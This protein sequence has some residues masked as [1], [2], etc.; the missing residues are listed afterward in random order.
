MTDRRVA[1]LGDRA[2]S[3]E[4]PGDFTLQR[5]REARAV[6]A[7]VR[8]STLPGIRDVVVTGVGVTVHVDPLGAPLDDLEALLRETSA[9]TLLEEDEA[10]PVVIPVRYGGEDGPDLDEVAAR[11][12]CTTSDVIGWHSAPVYHVIMMGFVA[13]FGYLWP[14]DSRLHLPRRSTPRTR[15]PAGSVAIA[16][17]QTA[18]YPA[19]TPG[20]W[21]LIGRT[22]VRPYDATRDPIFLFETGRKVRFEPQ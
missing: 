8:R 13:G 7:E 17:P 6:A 9:D 22:D 12:G 2:I 20:G 4:L 21:H 16:G 14:V 11:C 19:D 15:V 1:R 3:V 18:I 5:G 10:P